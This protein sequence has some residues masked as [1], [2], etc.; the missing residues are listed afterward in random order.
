MDINDIKSDINREWQSFQRLMKKNL[1]SNCSL[2]GTINSY[3]LDNKGKQIRPLLSILSAKACGEIN[4][5]SISCAVVSEMLHTATLLHDD[6]ADN[7]PQRRGAPTV[8]TAYSPAAS[9][10]T[11][12]FWLAKAFSL[13]VK[14]QNLTIL[15]FFTKTVKDL[16]EGELFQMQKASSLDTTEEDYYYIIYSKTASLFV[17]AI[18][19]AVYSV[20]KD[21]VIL[22][23]MEN[24]ASNLGIA[25]QIRDD[26]FDYMPNLNTG[27]PTGGDIKEKKITLPLICALNSATEEEKNKML[28]ILR[29]TLTDDDKLVVEA[30]RLIDKYSGVAL[31]QKTMTVYCKKAEDSLSVLKDST[32][33]RDLKNLARYVGN[34]LV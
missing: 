22:D 31:A 16:S 25:F 2:L 24:Y 20:E 4:D 3:L 8:Q 5:L 29:E 23:S 18:K 13:L 9:I 19:S 10:L 12:D 27:K 28:K 15:G 34:R 6:V 17:A 26:I 32:Y 30:T 33:K 11:G 21:K 1:D 14:N 7:A